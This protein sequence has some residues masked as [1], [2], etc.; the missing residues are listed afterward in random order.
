MVVGSALFWIFIR[1]NHQTTMLRSV[2]NCAMSSG[3]T[4]AHHCLPEHSIITTC[5]QLVAPCCALFDEIGSQRAAGQVVFSEKQGAVGNMYGGDFLQTG[6]QP[7]MVVNPGRGKLN[8]KI[9]FSLSPFAPLGIWSLPTHVSPLVLSCLPL[10]AMA[11]IYIV[12]RHRISPYYSITVLEFI[13]SRNC[14]RVVFTIENP[15]AQGQ[16]FSK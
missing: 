13:G 11:S 15:P 1:H 7:G 12:N 16:Q 5:V 8:G 14:V 9:V 3:P 10:S 6:H 2:K 4:R